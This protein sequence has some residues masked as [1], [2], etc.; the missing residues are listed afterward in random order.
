MAL[1]KE[2]LAGFVGKHV[3]IVLPGKVLKG[4]IKELNDTHMVLEDH[5]NVGIAPYEHIEYVQVQLE[6]EVESKIIT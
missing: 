2:D 6:P 1:T 3:K 5:L 4:K